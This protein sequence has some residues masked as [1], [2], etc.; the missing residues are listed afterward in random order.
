[1]EYLSINDIER[2]CETASPSNHFFEPQAKRFFRSRIGSN[3]YQGPGGIY[4]VTSEQ[5]IGS[6][7]YRAERM[8]TVRQFRQWREIR[9]KDGREV[10][11]VSIDTVGQFNSLT[12]GQ[13]IAAA[14]RCSERGPEAIG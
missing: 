10:S 7:G 12:R 9:E 8:F 5:F 14:K 2:A 11:C 3:V 1:M 6:N 13:A 4:F